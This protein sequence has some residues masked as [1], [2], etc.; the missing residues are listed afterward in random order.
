MRRP[1]G[2]ELLYLL[3]AA[4]LITHEIDAAYWHEW[5]L[6]GIADGIGLLLAFN[7]A[8][9]ILVLRGFRD[10]VVGTRAGDWYALALAGAGVFVVAAHT[11]FFV[12]G[13][14]EFRAAASVAVLA[15]ILIV[16]LAQAGVGLARLRARRDR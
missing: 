11:W 13:H 15:A 4:L 7:L 8:A 1:G 14:P 3:N 16:S 9:V 12:A 6:V 2:A 5:A 10:V